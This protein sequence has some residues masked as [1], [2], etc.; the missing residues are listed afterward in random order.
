M[1]HVASDSQYRFFQVSVWPESR[2]GIYIKTLLQKTECQKTK[3]IQRRS[4]N[5]RKIQIT[6]KQDCWAILEFT[7]FATKMQKIFLC[8]TNGKQPLPT[9]RETYQTS[10]SLFSPHISWEQRNRSAKI[11]ERLATIELQLLSSYT[12]ILSAEFLL[13]WKRPNH[14]KLL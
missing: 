10:G 9:P 1:H 7:Q 12:E 8:I 3:N 5:A 11:G 14:Y 13:S 4:L 2:T 6:S